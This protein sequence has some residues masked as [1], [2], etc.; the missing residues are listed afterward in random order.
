METQMKHQDDVKKQENLESPSR[1]DF[2]SLIPLGIFGAI[3]ASIGTASKRFLEPPVVSAAGENWK[4]LGILS[5]LNGEE[6]IAKSVLVESQSGWSKTIEDIT[7][8]V[9][10]KHECKV[11]SSV[12]PHEGCPI[13]W[14]KDSK[15]FLCPCHD[16]FFGDNGT[17]IS[18]PSQSDLTPIETKVENGILQIKI[19]Q[20]NGGRI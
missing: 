8:Y 10:P 13:V 7:V 20:N 17:R 15:N 6:P 4:P 5:E 2:L 18:G 3:A 16:S 1:R 9:L 19:Q 14:D 11:L 12:C